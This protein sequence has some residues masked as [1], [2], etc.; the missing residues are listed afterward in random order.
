M[1][2]PTYTF[3]NDAYARGFM[4]SC[5]LSAIW[6]LEHGNPELALESLKRAIE[7]EEKK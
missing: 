3:S 6:Q 2:D 7:Q 1:T 5:I 4:R